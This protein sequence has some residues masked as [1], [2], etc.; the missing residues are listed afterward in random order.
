MTMLDWDPRLILL[1]GIALMLAGILFPF[2]MLL[3]ILRSTWFLNF[4]SYTASVLGLMLGII[5]V[6][7][8]ARKRM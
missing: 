6:A 2:L 7:Y 4:I 1:V 8:Y 5:G 3:Q